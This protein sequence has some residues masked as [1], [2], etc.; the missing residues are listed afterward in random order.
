MWDILLWVQS[1]FDFEFKKMGTSTIHMLLKAVINA[2][3][4]K[5]E[6]FKLESYIQ[7]ILQ[8]LGILD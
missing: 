6:N 3:A 2:H 5:K 1:R 8:I 4:Y 7:S